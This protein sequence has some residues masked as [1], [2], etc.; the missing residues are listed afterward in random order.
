MRADYC[1]IGHWGQGFLSCLILSESILLFLGTWLAAQLGHICQP[2]LVCPGKCP[3]TL[4]AV[5]WEGHSW[6]I[7]L[8]LDRMTSFYF[9]K[10]K[11][12]S[13]DNLVVL[14]LIPEHFHHPR[15]DL[16]LISSHSP[17]LPSSQPLTTVNSVSMNLPVMDISYKE[18]HLVHV[19]LRMAS[20][21]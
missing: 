20:F 17:L 21:T 14:L 18:N 11:T 5:G 19:L 7:S 2:I 6:P 12:F 1:L 8:C 15:R 3:A 16:F 9:V 4:E 10:Q 13:A